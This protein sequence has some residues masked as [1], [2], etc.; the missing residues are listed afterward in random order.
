[1]TLLADSPI[2]ARQRGEATKLLR[3]IAKHQDPC[4]FFADLTDRA[5]KNGIVKKGGWMMSA[6]RQEAEQCESH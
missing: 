3:Q 1:M 2:G 5:E 6:L 4:S